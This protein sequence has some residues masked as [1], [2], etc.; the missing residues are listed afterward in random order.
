MS[1][2]ADD[3]FAQLT[4]NGVATFEGC[5]QAGDGI[6]HE[7]QDA[8]KTCEAARISSAESAGGLVGPRRPHR[9]G[10]ASDTARVMTPGLG[11]LVDEKL[12]QEPCT[13]ATRLLGRAVVAQKRRDLRVT[14]PQCHSQRS[15]SPVLHIYICITLPEEP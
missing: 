12:S 11:P 10:C 5:V 2:L 3:P 15:P 1:S 14:I 7:W 4:L 6:G 8:S 9:T 13:N